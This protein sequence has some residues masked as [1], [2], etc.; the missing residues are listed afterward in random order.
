MDSFEIKITGYLDPGEEVFNEMF[1]AGTAAYEL[2]KSAL[3]R[4]FRPHGAPEMRHMKIDRV[5][6]NPHDGKGSF[7]VVLDINFT[8]GCEDL[9]IE[10]KAQ[11]SE[12]TFAVDE[13]NE[14]ISFYSSPYADSRSTA[15]EF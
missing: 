5:K 12:W 11:T 4:E 1:A 7:R 10:K 15:D 9:L 6:Y 14:I 3:E 2:L 8:F 13:K